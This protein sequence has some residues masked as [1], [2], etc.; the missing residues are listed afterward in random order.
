MIGLNYDRIGKYAK[1]AA[2]F[3]KSYE[4]DSK[5]RYADYCLLAKGR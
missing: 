2:A 4:A 5:F 3:E 1:A